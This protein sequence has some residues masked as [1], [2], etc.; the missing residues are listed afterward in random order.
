VPVQA[1]STFILKQ[2]VAMGRE[3]G[4]M[5]E[6]AGAGVSRRATVP[7]FLRVLKPVPIT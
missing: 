3:A 1:E 6:E 5:E 2:T 4:E 7:P